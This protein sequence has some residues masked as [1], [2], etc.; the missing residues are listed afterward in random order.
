MVRILSAHQIGIFANYCL[1]QLTVSSSQTSFCT[2]LCT[3]SYSAHISWH[4]P[5]GVM[6]SDKERGLSGSAIRPRC[7]ASFRSRSRDLVSYTESL[8]ALRQS[9]IGRGILT[10]WYRSCQLPLVL[11]LLDALGCGEV[12]LWRAFPRALLVPRGC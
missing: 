2:T 8:T 6:A 12:W 10:A 3:R 7:M 1:H 4:V 5:T 9:I 11:A